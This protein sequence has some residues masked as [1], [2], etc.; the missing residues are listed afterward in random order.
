MRKLDLTQRMEMRLGRKRKASEAVLGDDSEV[1][2]PRLLAFTGK[3]KATKA[4]KLASVLEGRKGRD[5]NDRDRRGGSTNIEKTRRKPAS[6]VRHRVI[7]KKSNK[8]HVKT[9]KN[10]VGPRKLRRR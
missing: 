4:R 3:K 2:D 5:K 9:L 7:N 10:K 6:M 1:V 8:K